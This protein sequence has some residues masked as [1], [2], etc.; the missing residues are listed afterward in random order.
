MYPD[1]KEAARA[2]CIDAYGSWM[3]TKWPSVI[4]AR[5]APSSVVSRLIET[6]SSRS[7]G[8]GGIS[9]R[10]PYTLFVVV[11]VCRSEPSTIDAP[12]KPT[13]CGV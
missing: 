2:W 13:P 7:M 8:G 4:D 3:C 1:W 5:C 6:V 11:C 10:S 12:Q 9:C